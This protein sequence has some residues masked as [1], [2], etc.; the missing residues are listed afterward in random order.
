MQN[1]KNES[2]K[3]TSVTLLFCLFIQA[4]SSPEGLEEVANAFMQC[5]QFPNCCG[6]IDGKHIRLKELNKCGS[7]FFNYKGYNS[8]V[9]MAVVDHDYK[10]VYV[11]IGTHRKC[12]DAGIWR[13]CTFNQVGSLYYIPL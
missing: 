8:L 7:D 6:A 12:S 1:V 10:F 13:E 4:P 5:W 9:L 3:S 2:L 11:N